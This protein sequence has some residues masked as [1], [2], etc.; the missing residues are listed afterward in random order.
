MRVKDMPACDRPRERLFAGGA[1]ALADRE[2]LALLLG[3]GCRGLSAL[4]LASQLIAH[5]GDL[6]ELA[7]ADAHRL[8]TMPGMGPA[9]A[10]RLAAAFQLL[11]RVQAAPEPHRVTSSADLAAVAAP[12][13]RGHRRERLVVVVCDPAGAVIRKTVLT[14]GGSDHTSSPIREIIALALTSGGALFGI[15]HNHPSGSLAPSDADLKVTARLREA[16][17]TV[18][19]RFLDHL[20]ITD[21]AWRRIPSGD[22]DIDLPPTPAA[23]E[24]ARDRDRP[25]RAGA[26]TTRATGNERPG[27]KRKARGTETGPPGGMAKAGGGGTDGPRP[28]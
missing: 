5:C 4:E 15:A 14:E 20:I 11:R 3:S 9:K 16:A 19:L 10:A 23:S 8:R 6:S 12:L 26:P 7:R 2:L 27:R 28:P 17:E 21:R 1:G 13:L 18:G 24:R 22:S 25:P